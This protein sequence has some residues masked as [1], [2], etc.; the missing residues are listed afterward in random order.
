MATR[1]G[2]AVLR[3]AKRFWWAAKIAEAVDTALPP[4]ITSVP[5]TRVVETRSPA[6]KREPSGER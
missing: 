4:G 1:D 3:I 5:A 6:L 2:F